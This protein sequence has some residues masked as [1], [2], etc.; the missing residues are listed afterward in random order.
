MKCKI[1]PKLVEEVY[2]GRFG[3]ESQEVDLSQ[4]PK[5]S[6]KANNDVLLKPITQDEVQKTI[7]NAKKDSAPGPD[8]ITL[9]ALKVL[10][11]SFGTITNVFNTWLVTKKVPE[12][13]KANRSILLPKGSEGLDSVNNWRPLTISSVLLRLYTNILAKRVKEAVPLNPRQRGFILAPGCS[14]NQFRH[15]KKN[16]N[17][18]FVFFLDL[19]KMFD[20]VSHRHIDSA[21]QRFGISWC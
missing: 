13:M 10:D 3:G 17:R 16:R 1:D 14:E 21:L 19:A 11:K 15:T 18:L 5:P 20:I 6:L 4:Y 9:E 2:C 7:R 8:G 12:T